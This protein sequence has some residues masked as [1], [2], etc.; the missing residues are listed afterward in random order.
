MGHTL[1]FNKYLVTEGTNRALSLKPATAGW[2]VS[3]RKTFQM[4]D[5]LFFHKQ[6]F[7]GM[8]DMQITSQIS[9]AQLDE[10]GHMQTPLIPSPQ[11][12]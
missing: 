8:L 5:K 7:W 9:Y 6:L 4:C 2:G 1:C 3:L 12:L 11:P 10:F